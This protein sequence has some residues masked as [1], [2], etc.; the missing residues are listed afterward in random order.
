MAECHK[1]IVACGKCL[2]LSVPQLLAAQKFTA[3][4][5]EANKVLNHANRQQPPLPPL[6][7]RGSVSRP[8]GSLCPRPSLSTSTLRLPD[9][10]TP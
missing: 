6:L 8:A 10:P 9:C 7:S 2:K 4:Q 3:D 5:L 1:S